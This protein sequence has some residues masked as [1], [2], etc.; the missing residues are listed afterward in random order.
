MIA[1]GRVYAACRPRAERIEPTAPGGSPVGAL[2]GMVEGANPESRP[3]LPQREGDLTRHGWLVD[4]ASRET[5][6]AG[7]RARILLFLG[8]TRSD[9]PRIH[10]LIRN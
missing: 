9:L 4:L 1:A 10:N 7:V 5:G 6:P 3:S 2:A 8:V